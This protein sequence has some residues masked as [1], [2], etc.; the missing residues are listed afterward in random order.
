M[1]RVEVVAGV[2]QN[3]QGQ[4]LCVQRGPNKFS[5]IDQ[6]F[7]FPGGKIEFGEDRVSALEREL[8]EEL[9]LKDVSV[10][11]AL[12]TVEH[13][14]PDFH[15]TMHAYLCKVT[16]NRHILK[17]HINSKWLNIEEMDFLDWAAADIPILNYLQH[18]NADH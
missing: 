13:T 5:Y 14:Y 7:E 3:T 1:K 4:Y 10:A 16:T 6:K 15:L 17:E 12:I 9:D 18:L 2:I 11:D 8:C